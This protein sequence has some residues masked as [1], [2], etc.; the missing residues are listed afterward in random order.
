MTPKHEIGVLFKLL[1][2]H[3]RSRKLS[4]KELAMKMDMS[5]SNLKRIFSSQSCSIEQLSQICELAGS[6][7]F[8]MTSMAS[9]SQVFMYKLSEKAETFF[10]ENFDCFIFYRKLAGSR[11]P[12][13][14]VENLNLSRSQIK[15]FLKQL[16]H[17]AIISTQNKK[18][19][20]LGSGYLDLSKTSKLYKKIEETWVPWF[21]D[22][23]SNNKADPKY[24]LKLGS[25]GLTEEH[26]L[27][28]IAEIEQIWD[29]YGEIGLRDQSFGKKDFESVGFCIGIGPHRIGFFEGQQAVIQT[30]LP[31]P[32]KYLK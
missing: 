19:E 14:F 27:H 3:L 13:E 2:E 10:V 30:I 5:E 1:K 22:Q 18:I 21:F 28:L 17:L 20:I 8:E 29:K 31:G 26:R 4:Y 32:K 9:K 6:S 12:N 23:V 24:Y 11:D 15:I 25:T 16:E 7:F